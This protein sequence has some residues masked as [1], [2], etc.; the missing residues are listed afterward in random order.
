MKQKYIAVVLSH[1][2]G[3]WTSRWICTQ[4]R[5]ANQRLMIAEVKNKLAL[6]ISRGCVP[7]E[8]ALLEIN[9]EGAFECKDGQWV[10]KLEPSGLRSHNFDLL[11]GLS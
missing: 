3:G 1:P 10:S 8:M 7:Q 9:V 5:Q 4:I 2:N 11:N 6:L